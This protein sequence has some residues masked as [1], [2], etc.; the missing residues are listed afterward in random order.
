MVLIDLEDKR[1]GRL[2]VLKRHKTIGKHPSWLCKCDCGNEATV[3]GDHLRNELIRSCGCLE[4]ENRNKGANVK[5][6]GTHTR[7]YSIWNGMRKRCSNP[8]CLSYENYGGRGIK[9]C[10]AWEDFATFRD[11]ALSNGYRDD[12]TID[13]SNVDGNYCPENCRWADAKM[14]A[15]NRR[16]R[17]T[18]LAVK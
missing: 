5:H 12:L 3:R 17:R 9:V 8:N 7:I 14:Q 15:N 13:R 18:N 11:W 16:K 10:T 2:V 6:G 4:E 1:F